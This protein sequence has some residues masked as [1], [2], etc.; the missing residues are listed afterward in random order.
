[1][2]DKKHFPAAKISCVTYT[3]DM[4]HAGPPDSTPGLTIEV[5]D[6]GAGEYLVLHAGHWAIDSR[7]AADELHATLLEM[8]AGCRDG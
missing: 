3:Q 7:E 4:H 6:C 8:L 2:A 1:M 5:T